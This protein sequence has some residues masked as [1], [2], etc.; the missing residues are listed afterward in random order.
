MFATPGL[1]TEGS[2]V[3]IPSG[4]EIFLFSKSP[5]KLPGTLSLYLVGIGVFGR[6]KS[7]GA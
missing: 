3:R 7:A 4:Q 2:G 5:Y 6:S 1:S